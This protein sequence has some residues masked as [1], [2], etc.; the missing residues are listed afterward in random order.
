MQDAYLLNSLSKFKHSIISIMENAQ[1]KDDKKY[2]KMLT[3]VAHS[4]WDYGFF[5]FCTVV[6]VY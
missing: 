1:K 4:Y 6:C 3:F 2:L 5:S